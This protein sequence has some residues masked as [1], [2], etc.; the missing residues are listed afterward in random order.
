[1]QEEAWA[2]LF[3]ETTSVNQSSTS[4]SSPAVAKARKPSGPEKHDPS[5]TP[6]TGDSFSDDRFNPLPA[7]QIRVSTLHLKPQIPDWRLCLFLAGNVTYTGMGLIVQNLHKNARQDPQP[8]PTT[9]RQS[10]RLDPEPQYH[11]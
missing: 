6:Y 5:G 9:R 8:A 1:M 7:A 2:T 11:N 3:E 10:R 4:N